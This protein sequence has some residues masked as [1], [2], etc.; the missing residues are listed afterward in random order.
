MRIESVVSAS[1]PPV[2]APSPV[3]DISWLLTLKPAGMLPLGNLIILLSV[4]EATFPI[5]P[6]PTLYVT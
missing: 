6:P 2:A 3:I 4:L 5:I 1:A